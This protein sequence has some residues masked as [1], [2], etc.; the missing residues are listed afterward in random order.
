MAKR[1]VFVILLVSAVAISCAGCRNY[2]YRPG[3]AGGPHLDNMPEWP[4]PAYIS[5]KPVPYEELKEV[6]PPDLNISSK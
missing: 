6:Y 4:L 2:G 3:F 5:H 1:L